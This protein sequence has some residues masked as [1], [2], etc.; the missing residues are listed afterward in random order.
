MCTILLQFVFRKVYLMFLKC[1]VSWDWELNYF[2]LYSYESVG[3]FL[4]SMRLDWHEIFFRKLVRIQGFHCN[5][6]F[7]QTQSIKGIFCL[8]AKQL[9][10]L[11]PHFLSH[12]AMFA[13]V[14]CFDNFK[15]LSKCWVEFEG[16][17]GFNGFL[18]S[19]PPN[20]FEAALIMFWDNFEEMFRGLWWRCK[21]VYWLPWCCIN[22]ASMQ[23][24]LQSCLNETPMW[25]WNAWGGG[26][27]VLQMGGP[28]PPK[29]DLPITYPHQWLSSNT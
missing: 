4:W 26:A 28:W 12:A 11:K 17:Q 14:K 2:F 22:A 25:L 3:W 10:H 7:Q 15:I 5:H 27:E 18:R 8:M 29:T 13:S 20:S 1:S 23:Q 16:I 21:V 24:W 6:S 19:W 9:L